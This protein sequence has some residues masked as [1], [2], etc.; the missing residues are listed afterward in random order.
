MSRQHLRNCS[1]FLQN[2][3]ITLLNPVRR[4]VDF[5]VNMA[6]RKDSKVA[7]PDYRPPKRQMVHLKTKE[8]CRLGNETIQV[9]TVELPSKHAERV[10]RYVAHRHTV[11]YAHFLLSGL[12]RRMWKVKIQSTCN[13]SAASPSRSTCPLTFLDSATRSRRCTSY[14]EHGSQ[15]RSP[16]CKL[17][18]P[19]SGSIPSQPR[20]AP[21]TVHPPCTS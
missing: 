6:T 1:K 16:S 7:S 9:W 12:S 13:T 14:R 4:I 15:H 20:P 18:P 11:R 3:C 10:L 8:E 21:P 5:A 17:H 19:P 2:A